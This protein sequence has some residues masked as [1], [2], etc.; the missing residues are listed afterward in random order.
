[1]NRV[2]ALDVLRA[3]AV[4]QMVQ[5][6][7]LDALL[8]ESL[9][10][11]TWFEVWRWLRGL[12]APAFLFCA[13]FA[14]ILA[15]QRRPEAVGRRMRR[16]LLLIGLGY[17]LRTPWL[18]LFTGNL[19]ADS[20]RSW[21]LVDVL[22]CIGVSIA[23]LEASM[24]LRA[25]GR[26][27]LWGLVTAVSLLLGPGGLWLGPGLPTW[28]ANYLGQDTLFAL[29]PWA[30]HL[31]AGALFAELRGLAPT[32]VRGRRLARA[33]LLAAP[34][35]LAALFDALARGVGAH[36]IRLVCVL[37]L[38]CLFGVV[39][40]RMGQTTLR[41]ARDVSASSLFVYVTHIAIVYA[42]GVGL[43][44]RPG[45]TL[46]LPVALGSALALLLGCLLLR[47]VWKRIRGFTRVSGLLQ[48]RE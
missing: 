1:M 46:P 24:R 42:S 38:M 25:T 37:L 7:T 45:P 41:I 22:Q 32:Q 48:T 28:T 2:D 33:S 8:D 26:T 14:F 36:G 10:D 18:A 3:F 30:G 35:V 15:H 29:L 13:G 47:R 40:S 4:V 16:A 43:A 31:A 20:L 34:I 9:R 6:H 21:A 5:G 44:V 39:A 11:G 19:D 27:W 17:A 23:L 12:T